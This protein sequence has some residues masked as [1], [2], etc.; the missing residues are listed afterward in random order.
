MK[1]DDGLAEALRVVAQATQAEKDKSGGD[2]SPG[3]G[4]GAERR[5]RPRP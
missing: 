1:E 3:V 2:N 5:G 4:A